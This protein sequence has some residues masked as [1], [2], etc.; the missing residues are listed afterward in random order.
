MKAF[1]TRTKRLILPTFF[2]GMILFFLLAGRQHPA[3]LPCKSFT[4][5]PN[6]YF[7]Q[8]VEPCT[9]ADSGTDKSG[10][11]ASSAFMIGLPVLN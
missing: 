4:T 5:P 2:T 9:E 10:I 7:K 1:T 6:E 3:E 8:D 11:R